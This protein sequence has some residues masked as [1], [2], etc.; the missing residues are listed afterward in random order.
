MVIKNQNKKQKKIK[1]KWDCN[2]LMIIKIIILK[3]FSKE[4]N[5]NKKNKLPKNKIILLNMKKMRHKFKIFIISSNLFY[6]LKEMS[7][8]FSLSFH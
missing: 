4:I 2:H 5:N 6:N 3:K 1:L 7:I 8:N